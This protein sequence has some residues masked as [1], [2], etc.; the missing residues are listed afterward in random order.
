MVLL[1]CWDD[2]ID[3]AA[4]RPESPKMVELHHQLSTNPDTIK[5]DLLAFTSTWFLLVLPTWN[6]LKIAVGHES[7][8]LIDDLKDRMSSI[9]NGSSRAAIVRN[10]AIA[11]NTRIGAFLSEMLEINSTTLKTSLKRCNEAAPPISRK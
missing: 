8:A 9:I 6:K 1:E 3:F 2:L 11:T 5:A 10:I 4:L 7:V